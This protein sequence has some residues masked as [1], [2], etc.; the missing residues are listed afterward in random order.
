VS[1]VGKFLI[2]RPTVELGFFRQQ[3]I[4]IYEDS[5]NGTTGTCITHPSTLSLRDLALQVG[6]D[7]PTGVDPIYK[8]GP[9]ATSSIMMIHTDDFVSS[10]TLHVGKG[11]DISSDEVMFTKLLD[12]NRPNKFKLTAGGCV[13]MPNQLDKE[14]EKG[15]WLISNL[16]PEIA[17]DLS[18]EAQWKAAIEHASSELVAQY[19]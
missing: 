9:M 19:F 18:G 7:Y 6:I 3:V 12:G 8:G 11:I 1:R 5:H 14:I 17:F 15:F 13:W 10:N 16:K 2:T 4:F